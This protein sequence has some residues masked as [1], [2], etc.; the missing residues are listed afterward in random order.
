MTYMT[1]EYDVV[2]RLII[3]LI[4]II[5][6]LI[7]LACLKFAIDCLISLFNIGD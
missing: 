1:S 3:C 6:L 4:F 7:L 5:P 2:N